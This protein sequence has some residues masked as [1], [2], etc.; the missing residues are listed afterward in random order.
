MIPQILKTLY[1]KNI[2]SIIIE[3][4]KQLLESFIYTN[5]WDEAHRFVGNKVF[6]NGIKAPEISGKI[7]HS[8]KF[9]SDA[10]FVYK[11]NR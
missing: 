3:G 8:E 10:L 6:C 4:G 1:Q 11:N 9:N 2:Q 5:H 7:I